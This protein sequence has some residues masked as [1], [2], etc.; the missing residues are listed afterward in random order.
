VREIPA[1]LTLWRDRL[2]ME[3]DFFSKRKVLKREL[4]GSCLPKEQ[5]HP[6]IY[7]SE[8]SY[9]NGP[10]QGKEKAYGHDDLYAFH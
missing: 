5:Y 7:Q 4:S 6:C 3:S 8:D 2:A 10:V 1:S 9:T